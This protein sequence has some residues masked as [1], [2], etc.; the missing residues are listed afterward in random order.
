MRLSAVA[1]AAGMIIGSTSLA[2]A[3]QNEGVSGAPGVNPKDNISKFEV[4]YK[5]DDFNMGAGSHSLTLKYDKAITKEIGFNVETPFVYYQGF[6][7]EDAGLGD[8]QVRV[9]YVKSFGQISPIA[10]LELVTP[11]ATAET[12]GRGK[13]QLNPTVG[14]VYAFSP[15]VFAF[16]G[17]KHILSFAG[18][19]D[20][21]DINESQPRLLLAYTSPKG[22][23]TLGDLKFTKSWECSPNS[24]VTDPGDLE[25]SVPSLRCM[26]P[27]ALDLEFELG[28]MIAPTTGVW[29]RSGTSFLDSTREYGINVGLRQIF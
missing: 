8:V 6:G 28:T 26:K 29:V 7:L 3:Q 5:Y 16:V 25:R 23:W 10:G 27:Q 2:L 12:L 1:A 19:S 17:Y 22:W 4:L 9:R 24:L 11:T 14:A 20:R 15:T 21:T 18:D 13:W